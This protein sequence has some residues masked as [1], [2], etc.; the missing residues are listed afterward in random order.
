[1]HLPHFKKNFELQEPSTDT[2]KCCIKVLYKGIVVVVVVILYT[3]P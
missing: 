1:M 2:N 3:N